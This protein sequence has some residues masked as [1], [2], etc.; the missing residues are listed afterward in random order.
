MRKEILKTEERNKI[1]IFS[2]YNFR[3]SFFVSDQYIRCALDILMNGFMNLQ[4]L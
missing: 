2:V 3:F 4:N 1:P